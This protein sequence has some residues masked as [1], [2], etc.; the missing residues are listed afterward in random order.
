[1]VKLSLCLVLIVLTTSFGVAQ[2]DK[3][4]TVTQSIQWLAV[5]SN[6]KISQ[7]V[8]ILV[9]G[10]FRQAAQMEPMQYQART[11]VDIKLNKNFSIV[12]VGYVYTWNDRYGKQPAAH[13][14]NEHR[15]WEQATYK[16]TAGKIQLEHRLR[17]EQR[18]LE[19]HSV[20]EHG[21]VTY[22]GYSVLQHRLRYRLQ[23]RMP[24]SRTTETKSY[25][26]IVYDE[27]FA[28]RGENVSF[29][30]PDQNRIFAGAGYQ[31]HKDFSLQAGGIYQMLIKRNGAQQENN[32]GVLIQLVYNI[33]MMR[34]N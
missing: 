24:L 12:P 28:S 15:I 13:I 3:R 31:F 29:D 5:T 26:A 11:G 8:S 16:H 1:M 22:D 7:R 34:G 32:V 33:D 23:A 10:Q 2:N 20:D 14:N 6:L 4:E 19:H 18:F 9:D 17:V 30:H 27:I 25:Y 21:H